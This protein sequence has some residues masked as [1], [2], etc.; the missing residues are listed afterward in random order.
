VN[1]NKAYIEG[2]KN[3][4]DS[5]IEAP[6]REAG[7][8]LC[9]IINKEFTYL[10]S[11][12]DEVLG[13]EEKGTYFKLIDERK[14]HKPLQYILGHQEFMSLKFLVN[15]SVLIP[16]QDT[17]IL[18]ETVVNHFFT[19]ES[20]KNCYTKNLNILEIG[21]GSGCISISLARYLRNAR[22]TSLDISKDALV[23]AAK[24]AEL[25]GVSGE[26]S[27]LEKDIFNK[28]T[29]LEMEN[30]KYNVI[31]SNPPY[32][33]KNEHHE[34][35]VQVRDYEPSIALIAEEN[36]LAFYNIIADKYYKCLMK[37]GILA[38]E[39][40][41]KQSEQVVEIMEKNFYHIQIK[42]DLAGINRVVHGCRK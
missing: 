32:I 41:Y 28:N 19:N 42:K 15:E 38:V 39:V 17:E 31:I 26:I 7:V 21:T 3:L 37:D 13:D 8:I 27:F 12:P 14:N 40:G 23:V 24:N 16:R 30:E 4:K 2:M 34:L 1:I 33:S 18:V 22:I 6:A 5:Y 36:G 20:V 9:H 29:L 10:F 35:D 11:H 25:N